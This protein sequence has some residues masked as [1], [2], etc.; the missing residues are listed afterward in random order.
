MNGKA[1][2]PLVAG[3][4][5]G[6]FAL[7]MGFK[8]LQ[9]ARGAQR[10]VEDSIVWCASSDIPRGK[11]ITD[12]LLVSAKFPSRLVPKG[13]F[14]KKDDLLGRVPRVDAPAGLPVLEDMLLPPGSEGGIVNLV[15]PGY[16]AVA[17]KIDESSG[18]DFHLEPGCFVDV[19][20]SF[21]LRRNNRQD[22]VARTILENVQVGA[23]GPRVSV[24]EHE[25]ESGKKA[26]REV[27]A[28]TLFVRP[29][30]VPKLLLAEQKGRIKLSLRSEGDSALPLNRRDALTSLDPEDVEEPAQPITEE[31]GWAALLRGLFGKPAEPDPNAIAVPVVE[32]P[33]PAPPAPP[34]E[35][36]WVVLVY[37]NGAPEP[38]T[39]KNRHSSQRV[40][41]DGAPQNAP[42][43]SGT[44][45][46]SDDPHQSSDSHSSAAE[47]ADA[48][49][50][51]Q[52]AQTPQAK[53]LNG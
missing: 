49:Q 20:G 36:E 53:E 28:V 34:A 12:E 43:P 41:V 6:G 32:A 27:R 37:R 4:G 11:K 1:L 17:V 52:E 44:A 31:P 2:I 3:L 33:P 15:K 50:H 48:S 29:D 30:A 18:V 46:P 16:R 9:S 24:V 40:D 14:Q 23:V 39:F 13:A 5:I 25:E 45:A 51:P 19:V 35:P 38:I 42:P 10:P 7:W 21:T 8:T 26:N 47:T 22:T